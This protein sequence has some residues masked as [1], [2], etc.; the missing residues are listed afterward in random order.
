[1]GLKGMITGI[2]F[3]DFSYQVYNR[4]YF[5]ES[6]Y[7]NSDFTSS[8][9]DNSMR[10]NNCFS[11]TFQNTYPGMKCRLSESAVS[12]SLNDYSPIGRAQLSDYDQQI[13]DE[14]LKSARVPESLIPVAI[15]HLNALN[16]TGI[17]SSTNNNNTNNTNQNNT[18]QNNNDSLKKDKIEKLV[19][20]LQNYYDRFGDNGD[21]SKGE[22]LS[23]V[24][25]MMEEDM[26]EQGKPFINPFS[27]S[28]DVNSPD[29]YSSDSYC[30]SARAVKQIQLSGF[31]S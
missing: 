28:Y 22:Y 24:A 17:L 27:S 16:E 21:I 20:F 30:E 26:A 11:D 5:E 8:I 6:N 13:I 31:K 4:P 12:K 14:A 9:F 2:G 1:M 23:N 19:E 7:Y 25:Q 29:F 3:N 15:E 10:S 18:N